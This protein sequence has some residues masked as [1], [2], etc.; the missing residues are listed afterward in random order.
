MIR[1]VLLTLLALSSIGLYSQT[2]EEI[3]ICTALQANQFYSDREADSA[4]TRIL[5]AAGLAKNFTLTP[6]DKINNAV[7]I[8]YKGVRYILYD[9]KFMQTITSYTSNWANLFILAHEVGHHLNGHSVDAT[10]FK[11]VE[12]KTL[13][14]KRKQELEADQFA[15]FILAKL[16]APLNQLLNPIDLVASSG[17]DTYSTH[18]NKN[19]RIEA[20]RVGYAKG[21][22]NQSNVSS[23]VGGSTLETYSSW[24]KKE[25]KSANPFEKNF[26]EAYTF[27]E[28]KLAGLANQGAKPK[29]VIRKGIIPNR[30]GYDIKGYILDIEGLGSYDVEFRK[31]HLKYGI[32]EKEEKNL[33]QNYDPKGYYCP[34]CCYL[35]HKIWVD[36]REVVINGVSFHKSDE[37]EQIVWEQVDY[38]KPREIE[39]EEFS[40]FSI[41]NSLSFNLN[42]VLGE[43]TFSLNSINARLSYK[44]GKAVINRLSFRID[45]ELIQE[46][47]KGTKVYMKFDSGWLVEELNLNRYGIE[48][49]AHQPSEFR[50]E[51]SNMKRPN[52]SAILWW[53]IEIPSDQY[54]QFSL[55]GSS[56]AL[57]F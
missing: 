38:E 43:K 3:E 8:S 44:D 35:A 56:K 13:E 48:L 52:F 49:G 45:D 4:L 16:G 37:I 50:T 34:K 32:N 54:S 41:K 39:D 46:I 1:Y 36:N 33:K 15:A 7:A 28:F 55:N 40:I 27:G 24:Q 20:I 14:T 2:P 25:E 42:I 11:I 9:K 26:P 18:P 19:K 53:D 29:L 21:R 31:G 6:C 51:D 47:K 30:G 57:T 17:D 10:L 5:D 22:P 23:K 12:A